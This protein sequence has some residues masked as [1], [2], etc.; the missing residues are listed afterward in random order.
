M[1]KK[2][3]NKLMCFSPPVMLATFLIEF[4]LLFYV[5]WRYKL[6][7][8]SRL[9][10]VFLAC[11]GIFQLAEYMLCGGL[12]LSRIEWVKLGYLSITFLPILGLHMISVIA[13]KSIKMLLLAG[14][15]LVAAFAFYF[16]MVSGSIV[17]H[18]C[19]PNY[20]VLQAGSTASML[21]TV[22]YYG[23]LLLAIGL[24]ALWAR[25]TPKKAPALRW[26]V[27]GY[28]A[29]IIPTTLANLIDPTT[30]VAIP[31]IMCGFAVLCAIILVWKVLPLSG[32]PVLQKHS[33]KPKKKKS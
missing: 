27:I 33:G 31:S 6:T 22:Y 12:G 3:G 25:Q 5:L 2:Y 10:V 23:M 7:K 17:A 21:Y 28:S 15:S 8:L 16:T 24:A 30:L 32:L 14:Y 29:F 26:I 13:G 1:Y 19:A 9:A 20:A 18:E 11:L 4:A